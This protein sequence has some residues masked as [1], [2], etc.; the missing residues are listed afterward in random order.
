M[1]DK[2]INYFTAYGLRIALVVCVA[3]IG[4]LLMVLLSFL[5]KKILYK[6]RIDDSAVSFITAIFKIVF[7][8]II[9]ALCAAILELSTSSLVVSLSSVALALG[10]ALKE[11][12]SNLASGI[13]IIA[14]KPFRRG[15]WVSVN[16]TE[17][18]V[19]SI[20]LLT[21]EIITFD[22]AK[23]VLP[24]NTVANGTVVNYSAFPI[25]RIDLNFGVAYGSDMDKVE[26]AFREVFA[27]DDKT[28]KTITPIVF[29]SSH[30]NSQLT[31]SIRVWVATADYWTVRMR[32]PRKVY[33]KFE[34]LGIT[35]PFDQL[36]VHIIN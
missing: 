17:G 14:N 32:L 2:I 27:E 31:Y 8:I 22:N 9:V 12:L 26:R 21:T 10:L 16:G 29:M 18:K 1:F 7:V 6:T 35:I 33:D 11:S 3:V 23:I 30:D 28:I 36:D 5:L 24:N 13:V 25:R 20:K 4:I 15:D 34:K 19:Q